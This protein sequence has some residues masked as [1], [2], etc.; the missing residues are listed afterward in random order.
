[1][2]YSNVLF[3]LEKFKMLFYVHH[4]QNCAAETALENG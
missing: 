4:A 1:M 3:V 2:K